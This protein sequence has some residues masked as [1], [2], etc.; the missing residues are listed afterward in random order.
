MTR[1]AAVVSRAYQLAD[2]VRFAAWRVREQLQAIR[3]ATPNGSTQLQLWYQAI[4]DATDSLE[5][6]SRAIAAGDGEEAQSLIALAHESLTEHQTE[7]KGL[8]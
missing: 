7:L 6:I 2:R 8:L 3:G 4:A 5:A 1:I